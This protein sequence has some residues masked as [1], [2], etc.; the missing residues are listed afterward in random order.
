MMFFN[1]SQG[2][3]AKAAEPTTRATKWRKQTTL[4]I[5]SV[6]QKV[7]ENLMLD[8]PMTFFGANENILQE[9]L[10]ISEDLLKDLGDSDLLGFQIQQILN[11]SICI[12]NKTGQYHDWLLQAEQHRD[13]KQLVQFCT[14]NGSD[15]I[16]QFAFFGLLMAAC[17]LPNIPLALLKYCIDERKIKQR[18][19]QEEEEEKEK[20][21]GSTSQAK[22]KQE[23]KEHLWTK[24]STTLE[25]ITMENLNDNK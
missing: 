2:C 20:A 5:D 23:N 1:K 9:E 22:K 15:Y 19:K 14:W 11:A 18:I 10:K 8:E 24:Q 16:D 17:L 12:W 6:L 21:Q 4:Y 13:F 7:N 25:A 3:A